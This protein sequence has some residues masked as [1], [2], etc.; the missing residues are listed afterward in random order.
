MSRSTDDCVEALV[1]MGFNGLESEVYAHLSQ[2]PKATG[3]GIA[4]ALTKPAANT[5]KALESLERKGAIQIEQ[6][7]NRTCRA[8]PLKELI[9]TLDASFQANKARLTESFEKRVRPSNDGGIYRLSSYS[10]VLE[11]ARAM[12]ERCRQVV[13]IDA[14]PGPLEAIRSDVA[15][16]IERGVAVGIKTYGPTEIKGAHTVV[17]PAVECSRRRWPGEWLNLVI[18]GVEY[19]HAYI[20]GDNSD[21]V[22]AAWTDNVQ[23]AL[24]YHSAVLAEL[25]LATVEQQAKADSSLVQQIRKLRTRFIPDSMPAHADLA[26]IEIGDD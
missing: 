14:F 7:K 2:V 5:Y 13:I 4:Q 17:D 15:I 24:V 12:L 19:V 9:N 20:E 16:A 3:Y 25:T 21:V 18:D 8:I 1:A 6:G 22:Q 26:D 23:L 10:Q 11:R